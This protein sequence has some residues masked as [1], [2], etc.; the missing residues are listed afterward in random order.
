MRQNLYCLMLAF[1]TLYPQL[2]WAQQSEVA[3]A[4]VPEDSGG[5]AGAGGGSAGS[6]PT[7]TG[8]EVIP[9]P[10]ASEPLPAAPE[11]EHSGNRFLEEV[12]VTA[13]KREENLM[14]VPIS[15]NAFSA[16]Q[17]DARGAV[18][19]RDLPQVTPGMT[20]TDQVGYT[21]TYI[22]GVGSD[23]FLAGESS[24]A[25]YIDGVYYPFA[26]GLAQNF[27]SVER[28]EVL[29]GPQGTLFGRNA[30]GGAV[31]I[32]T[33]SPSFDHPETS[34]QSSYGTYNDFQ[35]KVYVN[36]PVTDTFAMDVSGIYNAMDTY[37]DGTQNG[38]PLPDSSS[39]GARV[40]L[41]W[42]P[43]EALDLTAAVLRIKESGVGTMFAPN[44]DVAPLFK[45]VIQPQDP[46]SGAVNE[47]T[48]FRLDNRVIYGQAKL[49]TDWL[50][51]KLL[52]SD[53][54][55]ETHSAF[56]FDSSPTPLAYFDGKR[57]YAD[58]QSAE[59]QI[60]SN[61]T[62]WGSDRFKW[63]AGGYYYHASTGFDPVSLVVG[64]IN[65]AQGTILGVPIASNLLG[66]VYDLLNTATEPLLS[67][68]PT[69][70]IRLVGTV[71]TESYAAY[72][73]GTYTLT[74]WAAITLG[75]RYQDETRTLL[76]SSSSLA[77]AGQDAS[78][79]YI[80]S[81]GVDAP[82]APIGIRSKDYN[83]RSGKSFKPRV[84][85]EFR[86]EWSWLG[87]SPLIYA[88]WQQAV[89]GA[90]VNSINVY[91]PPDF[92]KPEEMTAYEVGLKT[93]IAGAAVSIA[94]FD[95]QVKNQQVQF[96]SLL[97]GG[98]VTFENAGGV[99]IK[100]IDLDILAPLFPNYFDGLVLTLGGAYVDSAY[101]DYNN[102]SIYDET[103]RILSKGDLTGN[104]VS[105]SPKLSGSAGLS[106]TLSVPGGS[107]ELATDIYYTSSFYF[108]AQNVSFAKENSYKLL[109]AR[110][111]YLYEPWNLRVTAF[112]KNLLNSDYDYSRFVDDFGTGDAKAPLRTVGLRLSWQY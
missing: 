13:Q 110:V 101:T 17:L 28:V 15:V 69:G 33:K 83:S 42:A 74:D 94:A 56:D 24:V 52:G 93:R 54:H 8:A 62:T 87:D 7:D 1:P 48:F 104:Q 99:A 105:R 100:G 45:A 78:L 26:H 59:L 19:A 95:Y 60:L 18:D 76:E 27:G 77:A 85:L 23:S 51:M 36:I 55:I 47:N 14:D 92:V 25:T 10:S 57:Q 96:I 49:S 43:V 66:A 67:G 21:V 2:I 63:I 72:F 46:R 91:D 75:A 64:S 109:G 12:I 31:N 50:D 34:L 70:G 5:Q 53:Q 102:A 82:P 88:Q 44:T 106:Q 103:T 11:P 29:K 40:K 107:L 30:V 20:V 80:Q 68:I 81:Y 16:D 111:S 97:Q 65:L 98:A 37:R 32:I 79:V 22:R 86:P 112:G 38:K 41:R 58:V 84:S 6:P 71:G 39:Q 3:P 35:N 89:K 90:C 4:L 9:V 108:G 73:Q 61:N